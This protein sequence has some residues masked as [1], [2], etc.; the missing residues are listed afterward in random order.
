M[1]RLVGSICATDSKRGKE[2]GRE[3]RAGPPQKVKII[4]WLGQFAILM[5][6]TEEQSMAMRIY[7]SLDVIDGLIKAIW[8]T[9]DGLNRNGGRSI[10]FVEELKLV[11][12]NSMAAQHP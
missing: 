12:R 4:P 2:G 3:A 9:R 11:H 6:L 7:I 1:R 10:G 8:A 5:F